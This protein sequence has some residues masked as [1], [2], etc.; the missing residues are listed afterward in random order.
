MNKTPVIAL[1]GQPNSGKS[2]IFNMMTGSHQ[3]VGNWPGK[4]VD[5]KEGE[6]RYNGKQIILADLPGSYSLSAGSDEEIITKDYITSGNADLVL[7]MADAS[8][9][10]RS[11]YM[12][13]D[14]VGTKVPAVLIL[15]MMD[16]A[17]GQGITI[18]V[19]KLSEKLG[20]PVVPM[21]AIR[22]KDYQ[23][24]YA[25]IERSLNQKP[26]IQSSSFSSA[27]EKMQ[28]IDT[29]LDGVL[30]T[31]KTAK[32][33]F[34][35]FDK[36]ALSPVRGKLMAFGIILGIF[37]LA[38]IFAG[39][40]SGIASAILVPAAAALHSVFENLGV[41]ALLISLVCDVLANV[42]YFALMMA[43]FVLGIT[44]G[45]N[46]MEETGYLARIS[47]LFDHTMSK[48]GLQGKTIMPFFMGLGC[49]IAGTT[50]TR[51]VDNWGQRVLAIAMSWA[52][53]CAA[54]LSVVPTIAIA[55][56]GS[57]GGFLVI[58]SIFLFMFLMMWVVYRIFGDSLSPKSE[59]VG[60]IMELPPY[61]KPDFRN[62]LYV[63]F[64]RT[65]DIFCRALRVISIVSIVFFALT[66]GFGGN[67]ESSILYRFGKIIEPVTMF[68]GLKWQAFLAFCASAISKESLLGV[69][70]TLY[71]AGGSLVS[72]TFGAKVA[73]S[74]SGIS[75]ILSANFTQAQGLAFIF[76]ISFNMPC[77]SALAATA[78]E[79]HSVKW[80]AKIGAFYTVAALIVS[81]I[82][83]HIGLL[84][85]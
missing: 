59:R 40:I 51:V 45:F 2:T 37:L 42:L 83:Y 39:V 3:H 48:V 32:K 27:R 44:L 68:F 58:V 16:V 31:S 71:G 22:K 6:F 46:L 70:N 49:T 56:F 76:A 67:A 81:C 12:L 5:Q 63:T 54:T 38:M 11:L 72:S 14:F 17:Q 52:V 1:L 28:F 78:R 23:T 29:L 8:Q 7:V 85:F 55:L 50:G 41:H 74:A 84:V 19:N 61:H 24:L 25:V 21:S 30:T 43:S 10:K 36:K 18:D 69:L 47:F 34:T 15:N 4:T 64:Q 57:T 65:F 60:L 77:V 73:G 82:V 80:T 20:I 13:A 35:N 79:T 26:V 9:L 66:Y 75:E 62:I 53:P 33:A